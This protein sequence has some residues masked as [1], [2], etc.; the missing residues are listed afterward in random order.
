VSEDTE[1]AALQRAALA[2][3]AAADTLA[4]LEEAR[5]AH[6]GR[7]SPLATVLSGIGKLPPDRRGPVGKEA[8]L[9]RRAVEAALAERQEVLETREL[10]EGLLADR[11]DVTLPGA[12]LPLGALHPIVQ[13]QRELEDVLQGLGY[14]IADGPEIED[15]FHNFDALNHAP[16]HPARLASHTLLVEGAEGAALRPQTSP[17][18]I[19]VMESTTPPV[20]VVAP[21]AVYRKDDVDATHSPMFHQMEG[22]A[23][24]EGLTLAH[25]KG[26]LLHIAREL[27]GEQETWFQSHFFPFTEPSIELYVAYVDAHGRRRE[28]ELLGAGMVDPNV[29]RAVG[30]DPERYTGFAFGMGLDRVAMVRYGLPDLRLLFDGDLRF[31]EQLG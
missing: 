8:N 20:Y 2:D 25:L 11:T 28:M 29:L 26:T 3:V 18:Q 23:V 17:V 15:D 16:G 5:V 22:L 30:C 31:L 6:T 10:S 14:A 7:R 19:R 9:V 21:G 1:L 27:F 24:D 4:A 13:V 12:P